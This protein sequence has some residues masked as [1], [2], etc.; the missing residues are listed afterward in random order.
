MILNKQ[1]E[2]IP[3]MQSGFGIKK[4]KSMEFTPLTK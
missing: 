1:V 3:V 4:K 2:L